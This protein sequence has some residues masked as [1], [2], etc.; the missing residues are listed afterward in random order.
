VARRGADIG[1]RKVPFRLCLPTIGEEGRVGARSPVLRTVVMFFG[2]DRGRLGQS[3]F[4]R[5]QRDVRGQ[6]RGRKSAQVKGS[7]LSPFRGWVCFAI[8]PTACAV[9]CTLSLLRSWFGG[10]I[11]FP[12]SP[13]TS[14][15][16]KAAGLVRPTTPSESCG[17]E[18]L[19][20]P[21]RGWFLIFA[22]HPQLALWAAFFRSFGAGFA[23]FERRVSMH[24][25]NAHSRFEH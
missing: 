10:L 18:S 11:G 17:Y 4:G 5:S 19:L 7:F 24:D 1:E 25:A 23:R 9:G 22:S 3:G 6:A 16:T 12:D 15:R 2:L 21:L 14:W 8:T 13:S 20:S